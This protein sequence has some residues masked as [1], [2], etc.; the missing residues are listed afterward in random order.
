MFHILYQTTNLVNNKLYIG[1]HSTEDLGDGYLGSGVHLQRAVKYYGRENFERQVLC[2]TDSAEDAYEIEE[3]IV[4]LEFIS[5][6]DTYNL[7]IGGIGGVP[8]QFVSQETRQKM[9]ESKK[10]SYQG[11]NHPRFG[12][13]H[14]QETKDRI[15]LTKTGVK[16][17]E[18]VIQKLSERNSG[19]GNPNFSGYWYTPQ[20]TFDSCLKA[21]KANGV[22]RKTIVNRC[23]PTE[24]IQRPLKLRGRAWKELGWWFEPKD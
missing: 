12:T 20:G 19:S 5:R 10:E 8:S 21:G 13:K 22:N 11:E 16:L 7:A 2:F 24:P 6:K 15:S 3:L 23:K 9:S 17:S 4:D 18:E 14:T 1:V